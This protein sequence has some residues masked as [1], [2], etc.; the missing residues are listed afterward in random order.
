M[1][2]MIKSLLASITLMKGFTDAEDRSKTSV[3]TDIVYIMS[4]LENV[5]V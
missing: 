5:G 4:I 1:V 3:F 2:E